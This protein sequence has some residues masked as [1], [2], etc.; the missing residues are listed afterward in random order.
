VASRSG[1]DTTNLTIKGEVY[2]NDLHETLVAAGLSWGIGH[3]GAQG[4]GANSPDLIIPGIFFGKGFG[5][6]PD[7]LSWLRPFGITGAFTL[8]HPMTGAAVNFGVDDQTGQLSPMVTRKVDTLHWGLA[9]EFSTLYLTNRF[10]PGKLPKQEP[11]NQ[12]V[13]LVEFSF[14][15][16]RGEKTSATMNPGLS[17]VA[18]TWQV[19]LEA[20]VPPTAWPD[21]ALAGGRSYP[22]FL[23]I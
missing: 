16:P 18:V 14:V 17:Y 8:E 22:C 2:R 3:S 21:M 7:N 13:P 5:D 10:T 4:I 6:L 12:L 11:L 15:S 19:A 20:I 9:V 23:M 1:F